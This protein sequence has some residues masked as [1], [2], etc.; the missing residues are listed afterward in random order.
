MRSL[1]EFFADEIKEREAEKKKKPKMGRPARLSMKE[2]LRAKALVNEYG[3]PRQA[4]C[5]KLKISRPTLVKILNETPPYDNLIEKHEDF[6]TVAAEG[7]VTCPECGAMHAESLLGC[8]VC[9]PIV[10]P[11]RK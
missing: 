2:A 3:W 4:V 8:P 1:R 11:P 7:L 9:S 6:G 10:F 5:S